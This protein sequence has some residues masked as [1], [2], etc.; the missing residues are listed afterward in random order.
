METSS[1]VDGI[2]MEDLGTRGKETNVLELI[3]RAKGLV[4]AGRKLPLSS[5]TL[6]DRESLLKL[7]G[8]IHL[9]LPS[10]IKLAAQV[11]QRRER[12]INQALAEAR[13]ILTANAEELDVKAQ[14]HSLVKLAEKRAEDIIGQAES[15]VRLML[16]D[17]EKQI[18]VPQGVTPHFLAGAKHKLGQV[19]SLFLHRKGRQSN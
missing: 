16:A 17:A 12:I 3:D 4:E 11:L 8:E 6:V 19:V 15:Q 9:A 10:N 18:T 13:R 14:Q 7:L 1:A 2:V 5:Q